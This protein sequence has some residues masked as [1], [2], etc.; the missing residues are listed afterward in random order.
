[1]RPCE[2]SPIGDGGERGEGGEGRRRRGEEDGPPPRRAVPYAA[3]KR[4]WYSLRIETYQAGWIGHHH[5]F[6]SASPG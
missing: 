5:S 4:S 2:S 6:C 1:M 3:R